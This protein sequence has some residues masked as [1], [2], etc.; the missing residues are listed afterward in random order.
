MPGFT[1]LL[2]AIHNRDSNLLV[3]N[4]PLEGPLSSAEAPREHCFI[5]LVSGISVNI[6]YNALLSLSCCVFR[7]VWKAFVKPGELLQFE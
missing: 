2:S 6:P 5:L 1:S 7:L 3:L 4:H